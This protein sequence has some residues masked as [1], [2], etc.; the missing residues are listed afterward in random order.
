MLFSC[1]LPCSVWKEV[2]VCSSYLKTEKLFASSLWS[3]YMNYLEFSEREI[4]LLIII[5]SINYVY[6]NERLDTYFI[7]LGHNTILQYF[8]FSNYSSFGHWEL[9]VYF[10]CV[11]ST[12][13]II[14]IFCFVWLIFASLPNAAGSS[15]IFPFLPLIS[16]FCKDPWCHWIVHYFLLLKSNCCMSLYSLFIQLSTE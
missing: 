16:H 9:S 1:F 5:Y 7:V 8:F 6:H 4:S 14:V 15:W 11:P 13:F 2:T 10:L 3:I 12:Y